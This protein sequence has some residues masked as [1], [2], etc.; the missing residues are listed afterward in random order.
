MGLAQLF[1]N[2]NIEKV[3]FF[4]LINGKCYAGKLS[5]HFKA[6]LTPIQQALS[7]LEEIGI[8]E[9]FHEGKIRYFQFNPNCPFLLE[10]EALLRKTYTLLPTLEKKDFYDAEMRGNSSGAKSPQSEFG[11]SLVINIWNQLTS[12]KELSFTSTSQGKGGSG[13]N[14]VGRG[15]V[16]VRQINDNVIIFD[17]NGSWTSRE[18][19]EINFT[20]TF[21]WSLDRF[22]SLMTLEH[23]RFG[24][25]NPVFLFH[26]TQVD[27]ETLQ[28][29]SSYICNEDT[30]LG[31]LRC[32][33]H[34]I[35]LN[36]RIIGPKKNEEIDYIYT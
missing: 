16:Q 33:N 23:L 4:L 20:N 21:R 27:H 19:Q 26:L 17:E 9:S 31:Q 6:P 36:W 34:S 35:K 13:W 14:G 32:V 7:K 3:L 24:E 1:G 30:Y 25:R 28:S 10:L 8:L 5:K 29:V 18:G 2:K 11:G 15:Q 12:I 22:Q